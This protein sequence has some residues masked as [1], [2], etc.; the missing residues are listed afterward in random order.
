MSREDH[1]ND[2]YNLYQRMSVAKVIM[3]LSM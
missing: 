1:S 2:I 3:Y